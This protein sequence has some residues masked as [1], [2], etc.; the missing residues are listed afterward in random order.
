[1]RIRT[2]RIIVSAIA[3][4]GIAITGCSSSDNSANTSAPS[5]A[6]ADVT[7][8]PEETE[9]P[10]LTASIAPT[11]PL[12]A[13]SAEPSSTPTTPQPDAK[14]DVVREAGL[15]PCEA[16][17]DRKVID[18]TVPG[19]SKVSL[20]PVK[21]SEPNSYFIKYSE[22]CIYTIRGAD[23]FDTDVAYVTSMLLTTQGK[24]RYRN[25]C[26]GD[27]KFDD[28]IA[29]PIGYQRYGHVDDGCTLTPKGNDSTDTLPG[30]VLRYRDKMVIVRMKGFDKVVKDG[31]SVIREVT[32]KS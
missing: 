26:S 8:S 32:L 4:L 23:G 29:N 21:R 19:A 6:S 11:P 9:E 28:V 24:E 2:R 1:M 18:T 10:E 14:P 17:L 7:S 20:E 31:A 13:T 16:V 5:F 12:K 15:A 25:A 22:T 30:F 3:A 27:Q